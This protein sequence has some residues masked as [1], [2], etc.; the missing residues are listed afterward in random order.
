MLKDK[1]LPHALNNLY[2]TIDQVKNELSQRG[3]EKV[4]ASQSFQYYG[5]YI[6]LEKV[7]MYFGYYFPLWVNPPDKSNITPIY[8]ELQSSKI[9][10][11]GQKLDESIMQRC[12]FTN[13]KTPNYDGWVKPYN[14][15]SL[16]NISDLVETLN[17]D[18]KEVN[19]T[20][21]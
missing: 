8:L 16:K 7:V 21:K 9:K 17:K 18:L 2:R 5:F 12:G 1:D 6:D 4:K 3:F 13:I 19:D 20:I 10:Q 14:L 11:E 15:D